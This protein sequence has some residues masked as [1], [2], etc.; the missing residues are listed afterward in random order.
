[1]V[2]GRYDSSK[3]VSSFAGVFPTDGPLEAKRYFV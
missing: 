3:N 2:N 1:V